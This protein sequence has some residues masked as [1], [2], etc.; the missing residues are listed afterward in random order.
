M[1]EKACAHLSVNILLQRKRFC[2]DKCRNARTEGSAY[3][4]HYPYLCR[5]D[6]CIHSDT[7]FFPKTLLNSIHSKQSSLS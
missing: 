5:Y 3:P 4:R 6:Q 1:A 2:S 7:R